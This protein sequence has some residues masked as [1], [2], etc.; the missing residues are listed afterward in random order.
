MDDVLIWFEFKLMSEL[1]IVEFNVRGILGNWTWIWPMSR[2]G[3]F[4]VWTRINVLKHFWNIIA[5]VPSSYRIRFLTPRITSVRRDCRAPATLKFAKQPNSCA[6]PKQ[7]DRQGI[8]VQWYSTKRWGHIR[9]SILDGPEL[10]LAVFIL[11]VLTCAN[12]LS[13]SFCMLRL[14]LIC[15]LVQGFSVE[16]P[17]C[18]QLSNSA[19]GTEKGMKQTQNLSRPRDVKRRFNGIFTDFLQYLEHT[20]RI[21]L[22]KKPTH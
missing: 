21:I 19:H 20:M 4:R 18:T 5:T 12:T 22:R 2:V 14:C 1:G 7:Q 16:L 9:S 6:E 8:K 3:S 13:V 17:R 11:T 10:Q 15:R